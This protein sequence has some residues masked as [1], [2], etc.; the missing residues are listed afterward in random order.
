MPDLLTLEISILP[1]FILTNVKQYTDTLAPLST[2]PPCECK[3]QPIRSKAPQRP[4]SK[5]KANRPTQYIINQTIASEP[6]QT[7]PPTS[8]CNTQG[9]PILF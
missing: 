5:A 4:Q 3:S 7:R 1:L 6:R 9:D 2:S 8:S